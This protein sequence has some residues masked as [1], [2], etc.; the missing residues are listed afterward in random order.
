MKSAPLLILLGLLNLY[1]FSQKISI[2]TEFTPFVSYFS[3]GSDS[4]GF[5]FNSNNYYLPIKFK[6]ITGAKYG[7]HLIYS[8]S[9]K[10][11]LSTG[12]SYLQWGGQYKITEDPE[13]DDFTNYTQTIQ[14]IEIPVVAVFHKPL[15]KNISLTAG[16][17]L[18]LRH[19][20][21]SIIR[22]NDNRHWI[23]Q[24]QEVIAQ[25]TSFYEDLFSTNAI[26][27]ILQAGIRKKI[28]NNLFFDALFE[29]NNNFFLK[30]Y[31]LT[32]SSERMV[33]DFCT[34]YNQFGINLGV[35]YNLNSKSGEK[36]A[37]NNKR[38]KT[39][40]A[41]SAETL[42]NPVITGSFEKPKSLSTTQINNI[43]DKSGNF[44]PAFRFL[45]NDYVLPDLALSIGAAF[46]KIKGDYT[47]TYIF[48]NLKPDTT[49]FKS[50]V[51]RD[52][53]SVPVGIC[54]KKQIFKSNTSFFLRPSAEIAYS[55]YFSYIPSETDLFSPDPDFRNFESNKLGFVFSAETG[56]IFQIRDGFSLFISGNYHYFNND[57]IT[58]KMDNGSRLSGYLKFGQ[59]FCGLNLGIIY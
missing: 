25:D 9:D 5:V 45:V 42:I 21:K 17:G 38:H 8:F 15:S 11:G 49:I 59:S 19:T 16:L 4:L 43:S 22:E 28:T 23:N 37:I 55:H 51:S 48:G 39:E 33:K 26:G 58:L 46:L 1:G 18:S 47:D 50:K 34:N 29:W 14:S 52:I 27:F 24:N 36:Q 2:K 56:L 13:K 53:I 20:M 57:L 6:P 3:T 31:K 12:L 7:F 35:V 32:R 40:I 41:V 10:Y 30:N 54:Y 44:S